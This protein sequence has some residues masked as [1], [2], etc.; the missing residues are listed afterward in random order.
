M[1]SLCID[2]PRP[3]VMMGSIFLGFRSNIDPWTTVESTSK[4]NSGTMEVQLTD[5]TLGEGGIEGIHCKQHSCRQLAG[6]VRFRSVNMDWQYC[7]TAVVI[8]THLNLTPKHIHYTIHK[9]QTLKC[10]FNIPVRMFSCFCW[11]I[12]QKRL[13]G[14]YLGT[15]FHALYDLCISPSLNLIPQCSR[16]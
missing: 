13:L 11:S 9:L 4:Q 1:V 6:S 3:H 10:P 5:R 12:Y 14:R 8:W 2:L 7:L 16:L 15:P